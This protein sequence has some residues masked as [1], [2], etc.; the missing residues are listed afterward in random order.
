MM[1]AVEE[2]RR[3]SACMDELTVI[4]AKMGDKMGGNLPILRALV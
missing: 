2:G 4:Q 1:K 3:F